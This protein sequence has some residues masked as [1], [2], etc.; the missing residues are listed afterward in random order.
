MLDFAA[1]VKGPHENLQDLKKYLIR[2]MELA[3]VTVKTGTEVT[4]EL[5]ESEAPDAVILAV[6][7]T[8]FKDMSMSTIDSLFGE[9]KKVLLDIKGLLDRKEYE[10]AGYAYWRL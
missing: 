8:E 5:I 1:M 6:A 10:A 2:Q 3:G 7:H 9:G 4:K